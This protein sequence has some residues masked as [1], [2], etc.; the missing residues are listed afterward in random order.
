MRFFKYYN[1]KLQKSI[2]VMKSV[3]NII[4]CQKLWLLLYIFVNLQCKIILILNVI[5]NPEFF[6][7]AI[8]STKLTICHRSNGVFL[9]IPFSTVYSSMVYIKVVITVRCIQIKSIKVTLQN[10]NVTTKYSN[11]VSFD[12][13]V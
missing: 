13:T 8:S 7:M 1:I 3:V 12:V 4:F 6:Y 9:K 10:N 5:Q 11:I 2:T